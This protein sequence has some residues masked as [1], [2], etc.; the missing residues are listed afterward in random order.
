MGKNPDPG[1]GMTSPDLISKSLEA[2]F[3]A[4]KIL[5]RDPGTF[6]PGIRDGKIGSEIRY[7]HPGSATLLP[8]GSK[9][10]YIFC[11]THRVRC[12]CIFVKRLIHGPVD[13]ASLLFNSHSCR[14]NL[15]LVSVLLTSCCSVRRELGNNEATLF[16]T[17]DIDF[18][19]DFISFDYRYF[20]LKNLKKLLV[21]VV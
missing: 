5:I 12:T 4:L 9:L 21:S 14:T 13:V 15:K 3:F 7:K 17:M 1:Y 16:S 8:V 6:R 18:D 20:C 11:E 10:G 2:I 19:P